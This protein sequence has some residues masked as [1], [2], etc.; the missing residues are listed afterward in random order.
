MLRNYLPGLNPAEMAG[1]KTISVSHSAGSL[2]V[3]FEGDAWVLVRPSAS[4]PTALVCAEAP[5]KADRDALLD[6]GAA[7]AL[8]PLELGKE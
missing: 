2:R 3:E 7:L 6:A 4:S 1:M 5:T 8:E